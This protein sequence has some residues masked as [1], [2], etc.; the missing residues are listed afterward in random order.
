MRLVN[1][2]VLISREVLA[3]EGKMLAGHWGCPFVECSAKENWG[4]EQAFMKLIYHIEKDS[5]VLQ[6][7]PNQG[8]RIS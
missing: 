6:K 4:C 5:G 7:E 3:Q 2:A 1:P 8:C